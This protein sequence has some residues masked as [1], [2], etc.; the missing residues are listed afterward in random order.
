MHRNIELK[1]FITVLV[2]SR[3]KK[4]EHILKY[5]TMRGIKYKVTKLNVGDYSLAIHDDDFAKALGYPFAIDYRGSITIERKAS[6]EEL[7]NNF[8]RDRKRFQN[9]FEKGQ[10]KIHLMIE[11][12]TYDDIVFGRYKTKFNEKAFV[13]SLNTW[14]FRYNAHID[15]VSKET[16]GNYI[17]YTLI[18]SFIE[19]L[20]NRNINY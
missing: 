20:R 4:N 8:T 3:E 6:L 7:S 17:Y 2:D 10:G 12:A 9:E 1:N 5:F 19:E 13:R 18:S 14:K 11:N 16:A 15:F